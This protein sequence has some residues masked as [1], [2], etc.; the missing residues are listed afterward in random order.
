MHRW[1]VDDDLEM[2]TSNKYGLALAIA[3][4]LVVLPASV[5]GKVGDVVARDRNGIGA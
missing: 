5:M 3:L 1:F 2:T 4:F